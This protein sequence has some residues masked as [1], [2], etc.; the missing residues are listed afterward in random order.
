M[1]RS[2]EPAGG[3][4]ASRET[5]LALNRFYKGPWELFAI[6]VALASLCFWKQFVELI[7][8]SRRDDTYSYVPL[9]PLIFCWLL[10]SER[11]QPTSPARYQLKIAAL[12]LIPAAM[13]I[14]LAMRCSSCAPV[15]R[16]SLYILALILIWISGFVLF[17]GT[18]KSR[19]SLFSLCFLFFAVPIPDFLLSKIVYC[20]QV[21]SAYIAEAIFSLSGAPV[22]REGFIF[23]LP[24]ISIDI[25][26]ECSGIRSSMALVI[27]ALLLA[28]FAFSP[29]WKKLVFVFA[30]L[31]MMLIKNGIRIATLTLLANYVNP[32]FLYGD[33][34]HKGGVVFFLI[35]L[36]LLI[37]IYL[38]LRRG[39]TSSRSA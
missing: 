26:P 39:E 34:H 19:K 33:L 15:T 21:G 22:L 35:G 2:F 12:F 7:R 28:H 25:A 13:A 8:L 6:W 23:R 18:E 11:K 30:G 32:D 5:S 38:L 3:K 37:P 4:L 20:L 10:Y 17:M 36:A 1:G 9:I 29:V 16:L 27:L 14:L 24:K 31:F